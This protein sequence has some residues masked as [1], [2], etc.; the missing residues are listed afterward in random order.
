MKHDIVDVNNL[1]RLSA[2][3]SLLQGAGYGMSKFGLV[4]GTAGFGKTTAVGWLSQPNQANAIFVTATPF[5]TPTSMLKTLIH[6]LGFEPIGRGTQDY[7]N[8]V[9]EA[10]SR[11]QRPLFVDEADFIFDAPSGKRMVESLRS[12][13]DI[14]GV[15][16]LLI[17][18]DKISA[19]VRRLPQLNS[20][21]AQEICFDPLTLEDAAAI[22]AQNIEVGI[23]PD[24]LADV[25]SAANGNARYLCEGLAKAENFAVR[26]GW[27]VIDLAGWKQAKQAYFL[28]R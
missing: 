24:L 25:H 1:Q 26:Q 27:Q 22:A 3:F 15:P 23:A 5:W 21:I 14:A 9:V 7:F 19:K 13:H 4:H 16:V 12:V 8:Q 11:F 28:D 2:A 6:E 20:R 10:V 18:M 17:G